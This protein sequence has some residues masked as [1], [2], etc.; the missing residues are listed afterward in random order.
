MVDKIGGGGHFQG[1]E[2][3]VDSQTTD[4][5]LGSSDKDSPDVMRAKGHGI[6]AVRV[7]VEHARQQIGQRPI[8]VTDLALGLDYLKTPEGIQ[9]VADKIRE[10]E[11]ASGQTDQYPSSLS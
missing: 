6:A 7:L 3:V 4:V 2:Y 10:S 9:E 1:S 5:V 11:L 8:T